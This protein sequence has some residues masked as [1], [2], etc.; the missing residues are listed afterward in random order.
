MSSFATLSGGA[1]LP[2]AGE[3]VPAEAGA[4]AEVEVAASS[5]EVELA[6]EDFF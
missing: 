5:E 4:F 6:E 1:V 3:A 2:A